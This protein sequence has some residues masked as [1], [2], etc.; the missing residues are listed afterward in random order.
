MVLYPQ[1]RRAISPRDTSRSFRLLR[2]SSLFLPSFLLTLMERHARHAAISKLGLGAGLA[3][4]L[5]LLLG[6]VVCSI[7]YSCPGLFFQESTVRCG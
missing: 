4:L 5:L 3:Q 6:L 1:S 7:A 2:L